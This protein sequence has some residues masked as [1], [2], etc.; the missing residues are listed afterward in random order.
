MKPEMQ[1]KRTTMPNR[2]NYDSAS[3]SYASQVETVSPSR[4]SQSGKQVI[5]QASLEIGQSGDYYERQADTMADMVMRKTFDRPATYSSPVGSG[6]SAIQRS[7]G[8]SVAV[9]AGMES[10]LNSSRSSGSPLPLTLRSQM[11][12]SFGFDFSSVSIHTDAPA[13]QM[14]RDINARAFTHGNDIFFNSGQYQ[15]ENPSGQHLLA[16]ELTHVVQ[17]TG[18][19]QRIFDSELDFREIRKQRQLVKEEKERKDKERARVA[20]LNRD[21]HAE[22]KTIEEKG[23][24]EY[25]PLLGH[26]FLSSLKEEE[27]ENHLKSSSLMYMVQDKSKAVE[28]KDYIIS[29]SSDGFHLLMYHHPELLKHLQKAYPNL[30]DEIWESHRRSFVLFLMYQTDSSVKCID[31][32]YN[33]ELLLAYESLFPFILNRK[34]EDLI[35]IFDEESQNKLFELLVKNVDTVVIECIQNTKLLDIISHHSKAFSDFLNYRPDALV[36]LF[37]NVPDKIAKYFEDRGDDFYKIFE[38]KPYLRELIINGN[39]DALDELNKDWPRLMEILDEKIFDNYLDERINKEHINKMISDII[40]HLKVAYGGIN[41]INYTTKTVSKLALFLNHW[42]NLKNLENLKYLK[43][44]ENLRYLKYLENL[45]NLVNIESV[46]AFEYTIGIQHY[47]VKNLFEKTSSELKYFDGSAIAEFKGIESE[48]DTNHE[49]FRK[50]RIDARN[51]LNKTKAESLSE[52][53]LSTGMSKSTSIPKESL[54]E[55]TTKIANAEKNYIKSM[56]KIA[57]QHQQSLKNIISK[58]PDIKVR[59]NK[60]LLPNTIKKIT[61]ALDCLAGSLDAIFIGLDFFYIAQ[62]YGNMSKSDVA[63]KFISIAISGNSLAVTALTRAAIAE[64]IGV[65]IMSKVATP[66]MVLDIADTIVVWKENDR[67]KGEL[68]IKYDNG[69]LVGDLY[70][71]Y[72]NDPILKLISDLTVEQLFKLN[73]AT[74]FNVSLI[75]TYYTIE[76]IDKRYKDIKTRKLDKLTFYN[77]K[78]L[79][80][81]FSDPNHNFKLLMLLSN[82]GG[83]IF[84]K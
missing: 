29:I 70:G 61:T 34:P 32:K 3:R 7:G 47:N 63:S 52:I 79:I 80:E 66:L 64:S 13:A 72:T 20:K 71:T 16:H 39:R 83:F 48:Y 76:E 73:I 68:H 23:G 54:N 31:K 53:I 30:F 67:F 59:L 77:N 19:I 18:K 57:Q 21:V 38:D 62:N 41:A 45:E 84:K 69:S 55:V 60:V 36:T 82:P 56:R 28:C 24:A 12:D 5:I 43:Y 35:S 50:E 14:S 15:P 17:Q 37:F 33:I 22:E 51:L 1:Q 65:K 58:I 6:I 25:D 4:A 81:R 9:P 11:E 26:Y 10:R 40:I 27:K 2:N 74:Q 75:E 8:P 78:N 44:L 46:K 42:G 49:R